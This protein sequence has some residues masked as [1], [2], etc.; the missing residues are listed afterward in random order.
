M[1]KNV[2]EYFVNLLKTMKSRDEESI[3][4]VDVKLDDL[5]EIMRKMTRKNDSSN[6]FWKFHEDFRNQKMWTI[7]QELHF[8]TML[9]FLKI[10][11]HR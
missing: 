8:T 11:T 3:S 5:T 4:D 10:W 9:Q 6:V 1:K 7:Y 2:N